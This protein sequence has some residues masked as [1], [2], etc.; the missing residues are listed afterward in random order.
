MEP[1]TRLRWNDLLSP[2]EV[3]EFT[4]GDA[5]GA[6]P[7]LL[8]A[9][10]IFLA[11]I[12]VWVVMKKLAT[13]FLLREQQPKKYVL[14]ASERK[15]GKLIKKWAV[16]PIH[17]MGSIIH[18][19]I[20]TVFFVGLLLIALFAGSVAGIN[21]WASAVGALA[22]S[23]MGTYIFGGGLQQVGSG[24]CVFVMNSVSY[25]EY[26]VVTGTPAEGWVVRITPFFIE[27]ESADTANNGAARMFRVPMSTVL[28]GIMERNYHKEKYGTRVSVGKREDA[29]ALL[30]DSTDVYSVPFEGPSRAY[31]GTK[32]E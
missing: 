18:L 7:T 1:K 9:S 15:D 11:C 14:E 21:V 13:W 12:I 20:E 31:T 30:P 22:I 8:A 26:W 5:V 19:A 24:Y 4:L 32:V 16:A 10:G 23:V 25:D 28:G 2:R 3:A 27:L 29:L 17:R 6:I